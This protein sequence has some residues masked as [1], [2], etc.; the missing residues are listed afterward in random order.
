M[1]G[2]I[3][4]ERQHLSLLEAM[5][6]VIR[7]L[8]EVIT[9][10]CKPLSE[11]RCC[12]P[13]QVAVQSRMSWLDKRRPMSNLQASVKRVSKVN[14][15]LSADCKQ[16]NAPKQI[17]VIEQSNAKKIKTQGRVLAQQNDGRSKTRWLDF[18]PFRQRSSRVA[19][20]LG[21]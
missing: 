5:I 18:R 13:P 14:H 15:K 12:V 3:G 17:K 16:R 11:T 9:L 21:G 19:G 20:S 1:R 10:A 8:S 4:Q 7:K 6:D 2:H